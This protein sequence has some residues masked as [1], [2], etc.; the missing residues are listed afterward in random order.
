MA[1]YPKTSKSS[2]TNFE[3]SI[4]IL[5]KQYEEIK[6]K[7]KQYEELEHIVLLAL[8]LAEAENRKKSKNKERKTRSGST[9]I[10]TGSE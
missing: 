9:N 7:K 3:E 10:S 8:E 6:R 2:N 1:N 5:K 4:E